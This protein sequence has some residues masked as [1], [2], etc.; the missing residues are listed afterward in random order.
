MND[1]DKQN[2]NEK[3]HSNETN[4][5]KMSF[6]SGVKWFFQLRLR[7]YVERNP[8]SSEEAQKETEST[9]KVVSDSKEKVEEEVVLETK[10]PEEQNDGK[11]TEEHIDD[12]EIEAWLNGGDDKTIEKENEI[13]KEEEIEASEDVQGV[14]TIENNSEVV[15]HEN[16]DMCDIGDDVVARVLMRQLQ[17]KKGFED[18]E[19]E[20]EVK[21]KK[22]NRNSRAYKKQREERAAAALK[23]K[24]EREIKAKAQLEETKA[25]VSKYNYAR[26]T[27]KTSTGLQSLAKKQQSIYS[28]V[29]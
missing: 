7:V 13:E 6:F 12:P 1:D 21:E 15:S 27:K 23:E 10:Q 5:K 11:P 9:E 29:Y 18:I 20:E 24:K 19:V 14:A 16:D 26:P 4:N 28:I 17:G 22:L 3:H 2:C 25:P 8:M